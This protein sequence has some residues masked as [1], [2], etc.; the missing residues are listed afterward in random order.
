M[1]VN[2][3]IR[4]SE[5]SVERFLAAK[6]MELEVWFSGLTAESLEQVCVD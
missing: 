1:L 2:L 5:K 3:Q 6:R 4:G